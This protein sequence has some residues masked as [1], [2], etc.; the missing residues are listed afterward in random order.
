MD[1][2]RSAA[3]QMVGRPGVSHGWDMLK[4]GDYDVRPDIL[5]FLQS[6]A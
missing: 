6:S 1:K 5:G 4:V 3:R 2:T